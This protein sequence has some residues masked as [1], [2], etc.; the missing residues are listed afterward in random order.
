MPICEDFTYIADRLRQIEQEKGGGS[1]AQHP[2]PADAAASSQV[3]PQEFDEWFD[4][5]IWATCC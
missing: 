4:S 3:A 2:A 5:L 1:G